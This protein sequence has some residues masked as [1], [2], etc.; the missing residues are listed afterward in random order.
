MTYNY[1]YYSAATYVCLFAVHELTVFANNASESC[2]T[3][4]LGTT[5]FPCLFHSHLDLL[6]KILNI[7][8]ILSSF[9]KINFH[10][11][12]CHEGTDGGLET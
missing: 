4:N 8:F 3:P 6:R 5:S 10:P 7:L 12:I 9:E 11:I 1:S 2:Y